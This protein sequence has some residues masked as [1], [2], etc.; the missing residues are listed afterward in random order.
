MDE[1]LTITG[2]LSLGIGAL[3]LS[4]AL[5]LTIAVAVLQVLSPADSH[6]PVLLQLWKWCWLI[7]ALLLLVGSGLC[8][9]ELHVY[10]FYLT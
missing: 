4:L 7:G 8:G 5:L 10:P 3:A 6:R 1:F 2:L 9:L